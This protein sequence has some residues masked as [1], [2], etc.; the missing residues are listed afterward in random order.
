VLAHKGLFRISHRA[1]QPPRGG[2][3]RLAPARKTGDLQVLG[4]THISEPDRG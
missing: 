2:Q 4:S 3:T 1:D